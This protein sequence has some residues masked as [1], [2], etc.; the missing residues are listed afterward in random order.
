MLKMSDKKKIIVLFVEGDTERVFFNIVIN[1]YRKIFNDRKTAEFKIFNLK[2]IGR[3]ESK[4]YSKLKNEVLPSYCPQDIKVF[5]C[6]DSDVFELAKKP[7]VNWKTVEKKVKNELEIEYLRHIKAIKQIEDWFILDIDNI[8]KFLKIKKPK[9]TTGNGLEILKTIFKNSK[10]SKIYQK[11]T[12][13]HNFLENI[14]I[15]RILKALDPLFKDLENEIP[16]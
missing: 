5:C 7:P 2:G 16:Y 11:G 1:H 9:K 13:T 12:Y 6:Y 8:C 14:D 4:V 15:S 10:P 3:F